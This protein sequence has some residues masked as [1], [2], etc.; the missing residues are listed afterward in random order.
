M[1]APPGPGKAG[2]S[3]DRI[4][5]VAAWRD[6]PYFTDAERARAVP[7]RSRHPA[8]RPAETRCP[9][10]IWD[11]AVRHYDQEGLAVLLLAI[12]TTNLF[13]RLNVPTRRVVGA[14]G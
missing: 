2:E 6:A 13:N 5:T 10:E 1:R 12:A 7:D 9:D 8:G 4:A 14:W 11:E 3:E